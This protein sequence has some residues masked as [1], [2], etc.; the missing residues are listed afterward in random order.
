M[1]QHPFV[2]QSDARMWGGYWMAHIRNLG[3]NVVHV[4]AKVEH[5]QLYT[6]SYMLRRAVF[7]GIHNDVWVCVC[8]NPSR[9]YRAKR[10]AMNLIKGQIKFARQYNRLWLKAGIPWYLYIPGYAL[11][12]VFHMLSSLSQI[13]ASMVQKTPKVEL[14]YQAVVPEIS[15][16]TA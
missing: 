5:K 8:K 12:M 6:L 2:R 15:A 16:L 7:I 14:D 10:G 9:F 11:G 13:A 3:L 1:R 4:A